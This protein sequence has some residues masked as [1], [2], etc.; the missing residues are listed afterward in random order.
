MNSKE[1][2]IEKYIELV[3]K[4]KT[5]DISV[6]ELCEELNIGRRTF[7]NHFHD[8]YAIIEEIYLRDIELPIRMSLNVNAVNEYYVQTVYQSF[9]L[10]KDF[11]CIAIKE[12]GANSLY[13]NIVKRLSAM[14][15][16]SLTKM[17]KSEKEIYYL[18]YKFAATMA[19]LV[20]LWMRNG[21]Q[22]SPE[23]MAKIYLENL[24]HRE[25]AQ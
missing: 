3:L 2:I 13:E 20:N 25:I 8:R 18:S 4:K 6:T 12:E 14:A 23:F 15:E 17:E 19:S 11:Y 5:P 21:M 24:P 1:K 7:Y 10:K 22:E 16:E 9:L